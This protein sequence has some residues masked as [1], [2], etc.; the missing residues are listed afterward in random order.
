MTRAE[1]KAALPSAEMVAEIADHFE[2]EHGGEDTRPPPGDPAGEPAQDPSPRPLDPERDISSPGNPRPGAIFT[3]YFSEEEGERFYCPLCG[4]TSLPKKIPFGTPE[5]N[6][7]VRREHPEIWKLAETIKLEDLAEATPEQLIAAQQRLEEI[8]EDFDR[9]LY[10][11]ALRGK[12]AKARLQATKE[13]GRDPRTAA[14]ITNGKDFMVGLYAMLGNKEEV[15]DEID[16]LRKDNT[17]LYREI[18]GDDRVIPDSTKARWWEEIAEEERV[19]ARA[20]Y[21]ER[22]EE[23]RKREAAERRARKPKVRA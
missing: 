15:F 20:I 3:Y 19:A 21:E 7:K 2:R 17:E 22:P 10:A 1:G 8:T 16:G 12:V 6:A 11:K 9:G 18:F 14:R 13:A 5:R 4:G 23:E